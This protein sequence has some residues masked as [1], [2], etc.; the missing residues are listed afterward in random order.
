MQVDRTNPVG[1]WQIKVTAASHAST[2][3]DGQLKGQTTEGVVVFEPDHTLLSLT[4]SPGAGT[5]QAESSKSISFGF[6][7]VSK[8]QADGTFTGYA[9]VTQQGNLSEDGTTF[10]SSG[11]A[12]IYDAVGTYITTIPTTT[13][14]TRVS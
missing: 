8:Y 2:G 1:R 11:Q 14:A 9:L 4:P 13:Q 12:V 5:W 6:T 10:S 3:E 7:E